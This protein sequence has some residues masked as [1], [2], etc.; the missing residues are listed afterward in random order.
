M[1]VFSSV[2]RVKRFRRFLEYRRFRYSSKVRFCKNSV[3]RIVLLIT[4]S[5]SF[6]IGFSFCFF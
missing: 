6:F 4:N 1:S 3:V 5:L 2:K